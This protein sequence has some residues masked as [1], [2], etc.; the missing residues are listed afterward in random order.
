MPF[1]VATYVKRP[2]AREAYYAIWHERLI[3]MIGHPTLTIVVIA[4]NY[5]G[6]DKAA[7]QI[8]NIALEALNFARCEV[9]QVRARV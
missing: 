3:V 1:K 4:W 5:V 9:M 8:V 2:R 6:E 7:A